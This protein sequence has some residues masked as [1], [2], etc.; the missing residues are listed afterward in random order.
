MVS[1]S[2]RNQERFVVEEVL[3]VVVQQDEFG[4]R[5]EGSL[6]LGKIRD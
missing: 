2:E 1:V 5:K 6:L 3:V 4:K